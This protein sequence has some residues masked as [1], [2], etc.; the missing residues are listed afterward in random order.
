MDS[1]VSDVAQSA[2]LPEIT[3]GYF[4][5]ANLTHYNDLS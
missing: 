5:R 3:S 2:Y 1:D 4:H